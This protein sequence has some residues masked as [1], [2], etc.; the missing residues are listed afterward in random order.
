MNE[1]R[2]GTQEFS[3]KILYNSAHEQQ[4]FITEAIFSY[5]N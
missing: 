4:V 1:L 5:N 3:S 2:K